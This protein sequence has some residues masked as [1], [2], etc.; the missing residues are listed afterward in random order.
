[1]C[2]AGFDAVNEIFIRNQARRQIFVYFFNGRPLILRDVPHAKML[3][4]HNLS[5]RRPLD[6]KIRINAAAVE[7]ELAFIAI[8]F[9]IYEFV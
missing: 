9:A 6:H 8:S 2:V 5:I 3:P 7:W 1:M 4:N